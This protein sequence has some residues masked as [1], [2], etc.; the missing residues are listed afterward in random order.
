MYTEKKT[1]GNETG[2]WLLSDL[3]LKLKAEIGGVPEL[4][5]ILW[6]S[7]KVPEICIINHFLKKDISNIRD[8][9]EKRSIT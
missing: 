5:F 6:S 3:K 9:A 4:F 7:K 1:F 8:L 2:G